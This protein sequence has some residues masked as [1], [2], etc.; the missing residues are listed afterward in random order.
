M[1]SVYCEQGKYGEA[2]ALYE[3]A[4]KISE[5]KQG[6]DH[7]STA[8]TLNDLAGLCKRQGRYTEAELLYERALRIR[9]EKPGPNHP[10]TAETLNDLAGLYKKQGADK[11]GDQNLR[12]SLIISSACW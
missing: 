6:R 5:E 4:L 10:D 1:A 12:R 3:R 7:P 2:E 8:N 11:C 9:E